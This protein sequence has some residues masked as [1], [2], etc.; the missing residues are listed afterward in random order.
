[1]GGVAVMMICLARGRRPVDGYAVRQ[2][3]APAEPT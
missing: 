3:I 1:M 2:I